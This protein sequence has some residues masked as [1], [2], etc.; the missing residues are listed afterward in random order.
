MQTVTEA[1]HEGGRRDV[2]EAL[3]DKLAAVIDSTE[4]A[5][6]LPPLVKRL[7]EV[8]RELA[9]L[10]AERKAKSKLQNMQELRRHA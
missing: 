9:E 4:S 8:E 3:R 1:V 6:D 2:L 5:R 7:Q 10:P